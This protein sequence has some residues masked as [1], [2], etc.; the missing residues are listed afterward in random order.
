MGEDLID[1]Y[2]RVFDLPNISIVGLG[3][4]L[5]CLYGVMPSADKL[6]QLGLYIQLIEARFNK[7]IPWVSV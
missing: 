6:V 3:T 1:F 7:K 4:N 5:N 2:S